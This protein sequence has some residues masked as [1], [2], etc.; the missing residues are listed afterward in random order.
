MQGDPWTCHITADMDE[1]WSYIRNQFDSHAGWGWMAL[2][3]SV[4]SLTEKLI[5]KNAI[6]LEF[7]EGSLD[8][9]E[10]NTLLALVI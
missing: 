2:S 10:G 6:K 8:N 7:T 3:V 5:K 1:V 4:E 9:K